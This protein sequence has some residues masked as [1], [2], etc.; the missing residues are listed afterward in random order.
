MAITAELKKTIDTKPFYA[1]AGVVDL[2]VEQLRAVPTL[3]SGEAYG[4][5]VARGRSVVGRI[6][7][8]K[9]T[10][11]LEDQ[12]TSTVRRTKATA[13]TARRSAEATRS[14]AKGT[15][16]TARK[17]AASTKTAAKGA[18]TSARKTTRAAAKAAGDGAAKV[19]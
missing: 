16:T 13:T 5:L 3:A 4:E 14:S 7:R 1:V 15:A 18:T 12:A 19:G 2:T 17:R 10:Q 8:Q 11:E 6:R 9:A